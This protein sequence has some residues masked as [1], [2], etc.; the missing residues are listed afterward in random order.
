LV[1][2][3][4]GRVGAVFLGSSVCPLRLLPSYLVSVTCYSTC[5]PLLLTKL[6]SILCSSATCVIRSLI[7][8]SRLTISSV[9]RIYIVRITS[10]CCRCSSIACLIAFISFFI[11]LLMAYST[12][13]GRKTTAS[14]SGLTRIVISSLPARIACVPGWWVA[15][16]LGSLLV[17][18]ADCSRPRGTSVLVV[19]MLAVRSSISNG[20]SLS[21]VLVSQSSSLPLDRLTGQSLTPIVR[22][23]SVSPG[24]TVFTKPLPC[25]S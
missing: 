9:R 13:S 8:S 10:V 3:T 2:V 5:L 11:A 20:S 14:T 24:T 4:C 23:Q 18:A 22:P 19:Y 6:S 7:L 17:C 16:P 1:G 12:N 25:S 15:L 21:P